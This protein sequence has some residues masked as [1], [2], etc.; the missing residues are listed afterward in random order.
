MSVA[1]EIQVVEIA[2]S[3]FY[4]HKKYYYNNNSSDHL[5]R[6]GIKIGIL[7]SPDSFTAGEEA[8]SLELKN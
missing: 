8:A 5:S 4:F 7:D 6:R 2:T 3:N 1:T